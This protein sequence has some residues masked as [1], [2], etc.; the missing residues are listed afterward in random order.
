MPGLQSVSNSSEEDSDDD[1]GS[2]SDDGGED[3]DGSGYNTEEEDELRDLLREAMDIAHE[4][5]FF[6]PTNSSPDPDAYAEE[7]KSNPFLKLLGSL[8]GT[9][10]CFLTCI[11]NIVAM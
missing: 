5:A 2:G 8:R 1:I 10:F 3:S 11:R 9:F 7:R 6:D 4:S